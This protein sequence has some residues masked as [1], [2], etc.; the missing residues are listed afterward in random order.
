MNDPQTI[1]SA[2][3][4]DP[5]G[6]RPRM[7]L[8]GCHRSGTTLIMELLWH[9]FRFGGRVPHEASLFEPI[10]DGD[11][12]Y[13]TKKPPDTRW[14][15][16]VFPADRNLYVLAMIRDPRSVISSMHAAKPGRYFRSY[17]VWEDFDR[18]IERLEDHPRFFCL[19]YESLLADP[20]A[21]QAQIAARFP[22]LKRT[23][24]FGDFPDGFD[25]DPGAATSL[26]GARPFEATR[27]RSWEDHLPRVKAQL[28]QHPQMTEALIRR[29]YEEDAGWTAMLDS[30]APAHQQFKNARPGPLRRFETWLRF[31]RRIARYRRARGLHA[32]TS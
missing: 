14:I 27:V 25:I 15:E 10:P 20:A 16:A 2:P 24:A 19:R 7:H 32:A 5:A 28:A 4:P 13:L 26:N 1:A 31:Q 12:V 6:P 29:G 30:V 23:G 8:V 17:H 18:V 3:A 21:A 9:C 22:F 11:G